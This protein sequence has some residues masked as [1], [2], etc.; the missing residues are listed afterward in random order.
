MT[1]EDKLVKMESML[2]KA[3]DFYAS[4]INAIRWALEMEGLYKADIQLA[5]KPIRDEVIKSDLDKVDLTNILDVALWSQRTYDV[6]HALRNNVE[7]LDSVE[8]V[9]V[10]MQGHGMK[11]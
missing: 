7:T 8:S 6:Y 1:I 2:R 9:R 5:G 3:E 11:I 10:H 4:W